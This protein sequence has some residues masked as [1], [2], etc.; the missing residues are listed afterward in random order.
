VEIL[1][2]AIVSPVV[3]EQAGAHIGT[4][5]KSLDNDRSFAR[6]FD[7][8]IA[9]HE[10]STAE[11]GADTGAGESKEIHNGVPLQS[12]DETVATSAAVR[13]QGVASQA[14]A[15]AQVD[16]E[17][18]SRMNSQ[19]EALTVVGGSQ[20]TATPRVVAGE[21]GDIASVP[22]ET[23]VVVTSG[24]S[25]ALQGRIDAVSANESVGR[26]VFDTSEEVAVDGGFLQL[27]GVEARVN[28]K[29][30][31]I[32]KQGP[33]TSAKKALKGVDD[34]AKHSGTLKN[35]I[36]AKNEPIG[37]GK[38]V[39]VISAQSVSPIPVAIPILPSASVPVVL[40]PGDDRQRTKGN[41][42]QSSSVV[43]GVIDRKNV[44][45]SSATKDRT[46]VQDGK[47][48]A[49]DTEPT[50]LAAGDVSTSTKSGPE[51]SKTV[52]STTPGGA[53]SNQKMGRTGIIGTPAQADAGMTGHLAGMVAGAI[54]AH[55]VSVGVSAKLQSGESGTSATA[56][57]AGTIEPDGL[58]AAITPGDGGH[59]TLMAT[60]T[61]LEV[62]ISN[63]TQGWLKVRAEMASGGGINA[64]LS[65][66]IPA[67]QEMLHRE[68]P[69]LTAYLQ[70]ERVAV[71]SVV[72]HAS[73]TAGTDSRGFAGGMGSD[74]GGQAQQ[75]SDEGAAGRQMLNGASGY[76]DD[77]T[78]EGAS[79]VDADGLLS[80]LRYA[81]GGS[82]LSVRA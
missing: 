45:A 29:D 1:A 44:V 20:S 70:Q 16:G 47:V 61:A 7:E 15:F 24:P 39:E 60:P 11:I 19:N 32:T 21:L 53:D 57:H 14:T 27:H 23:A 41:A 75:R 78:H 48:S 79:T 59:R 25:V 68:L 35:A 34:E 71:N 82:W 49:A 54:S 69:A 42:S 66:T 6:S 65:A 5:E 33:T 10:T 55:V 81:V 2:A 73:A 18:H 31:A 8:R 63:G 46:G 51:L 74:G 72:V 37:T 62:G 22:V 9:L 52:T 13:R 77:I 58:G 40:L 12:S 26:K 30:I 28:E 56:A 3:I 17:I 4:S 80:P 64:S 36:V 43:A 67:G 76:T 50:K 38:S